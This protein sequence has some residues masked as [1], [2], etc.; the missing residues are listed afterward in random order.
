MKI[1]NVSSANQHV[2]EMQ[3]TQVTPRGSIES[4]GTFHLFDQNNRQH[5]VTSSGP[6]T[7]IS[8]S[9]DPTPV[10]TSMIITPY[11]GVETHSHSDVRMPHFLG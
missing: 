11:R 8:V 6:Q 2:D 9:E 7:N 5:I 3:P 4:K 1:E 10:G